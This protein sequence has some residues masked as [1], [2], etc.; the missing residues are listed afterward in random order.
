MALGRRD[1]ARLQHMGVDH[2]SAHILMSKKLL[3]GA[4][5]CPEPQVLG[6][7]AVLEQMGGKGVN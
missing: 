5:T 7:A 2:G 3:D 1:A 4:G 6:I